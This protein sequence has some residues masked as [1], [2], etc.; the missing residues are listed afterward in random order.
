MLIYISNLLEFCF[1]IRYVFCD[2][3]TEK[4]NY[5]DL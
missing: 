1:F 3:K 2:I 5:G 4:L